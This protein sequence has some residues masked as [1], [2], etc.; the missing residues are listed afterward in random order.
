MQWVSGARAV[1]AGGAR[2]VWAGVEHVQCELVGH[3]QCELVGHVQWAQLEV[4]IGHQSVG[5]LAGNT[6]TW[7]VGFSKSWGSQTVQGRGA[8]SLAHFP[9][10]PIYHW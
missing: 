2:A 9:Y 4:L 6:E 3:V 1:W 10:I 5:V 7:G 8:L